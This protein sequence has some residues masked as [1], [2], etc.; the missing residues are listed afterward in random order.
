MCGLGACCIPDSQ[1]QKLAVCELCYY[2]YEI[3]HLAQRLH[4]GFPHRQ[5]FLNEHRQHLITEAKLFYLAIRTAAAGQSSE[6]SAGPACLESSL[7]S[8]LGD[9]TMESSSWHFCA[10]EM[11]A[12]QPEQQFHKPFPIPAPATA[13][14]F[15]CMGTCTKDVFVRPCVDCGLR[16]GN[17]CDYCFAAQRVLDEVWLPYQKTPL[18]PDCRRLELQSCHFCRGLEWCRP[19]AS[20]FLLFADKWH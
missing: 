6:S 10:R 13:P 11:N 14:D 4:V 17:T 2:T 20:Q 19:P 9:G 8:T 18:C 7:F 5:H 3:R 1:G 12:T 16:T 15:I